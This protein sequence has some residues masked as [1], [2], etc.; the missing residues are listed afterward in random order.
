MQR[1]AEAAPDVSTFSVTGWEG[2]GLGP[3]GTSG[4]SPP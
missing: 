3:H 1:V 2:P 4:N